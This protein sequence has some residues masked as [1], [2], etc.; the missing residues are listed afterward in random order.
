VSRPL[1]TSRGQA[2]PRSNCRENVAAQAQRAA[3]Q[4]GPVARAKQAPVRVRVPV[5]VDR[6][7]DRTRLPLIA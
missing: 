4:E 2:R 5:P 3:V 1:P 6:M 7:A